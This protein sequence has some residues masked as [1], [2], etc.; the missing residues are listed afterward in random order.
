MALW[1]GKGLTLAR[2]KTYQM[3]CFRAL[4]NYRDFKIH[5]KR[6]LENKQKKDRIK[7]MRDVFQGWMK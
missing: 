2:M 1:S 4:K 3:R 6:V 5:A 7:K